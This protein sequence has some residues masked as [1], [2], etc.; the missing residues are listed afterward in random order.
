MKIEST[1][2]EVNASQEAVFDFFRDISN[3]K[4][5]LP[6]EKISE[7]KSTSSECSFKAQGALN[8]SLVQDGNEG[9]NIVYMKSGVKSPFPFRLSIY[10]LPNGNK[11][12][13]YIEFNGDVNLFLKK[14]VEKPLTNLFND[15][16]QKLKEYF[17]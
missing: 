15:M 14:I 9:G 7:W 4:H 8:I 6:E 13:G 2:V 3:L 12:N 5:L 11:T 1:K 17:V 10:M 16:A